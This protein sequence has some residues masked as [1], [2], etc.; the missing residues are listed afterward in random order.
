MDGNPTMNL[1][2]GVPNGMLQSPQVLPTLR[3]NQE[4]LYR[5]LARHSPYFRSHRAAIENATAF[6]KMKQLRVSQ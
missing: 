2:T 4:E 5:F 3:S 1:L 6:D